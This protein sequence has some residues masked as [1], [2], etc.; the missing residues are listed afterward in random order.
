MFIK[1]F[2]QKFYKKVFLANGKCVEKF[3]SNI[4]YYIDV[5]VVITASIKQFIKI[6]Y[7]L[8][9]VAEREIDCF[10]NFLYRIF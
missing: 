5:F 10:F 9:F 2:I 6:L 8:I 4:L 1:Y 3:S 7:I